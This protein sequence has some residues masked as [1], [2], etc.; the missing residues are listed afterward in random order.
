M[1]QRIDLK[2]QP[3]LK[4]VHLAQL[5]QA[6]ED[7]LPVLVAGEIVVG[8]EESLDAFGRIG[9]NDGL[10]VVGRAIARLAAL[11]IDDGAKA[12]LERTAPASIEAGVGADHLRREL[13]RQEWEG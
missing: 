8:E 1:A 4:P 6:V 2:Q 5:D 13:F 10:D 11:H 7:R 9:A 3:D 12:A